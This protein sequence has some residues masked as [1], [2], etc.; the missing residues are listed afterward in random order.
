MKDVAQ[1]RCFVI[2]PIGEPGSATRNRSD[3][4]LEYIIRPA[5]PGWHVERGDEP[6]RP[7]MVG[8]NVMDA[9]FNWELAIAD[10]TDLNPNV[11]YEI[12]LR[13]MEEKPLILIAHKGTG[14]PFDTS[15]VR[16]VFYSLEDPDAHKLASKKIADMVAAVTA[17]GYKVSNPVT[18]ARG[19]LKLARSTDSRDQIVAN[20]AAELAAVKAQLSALSNRQD[21]YLTAVANLKPVITQTSTFDI[22]SLEDDPMYQRLKELSKKHRLKLS[23]GEVPES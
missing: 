20:L 5:L 22:S 23:E 15:G 6:S 19:A 9:I 21:N 16:D 12:A 18:N 1:K 10:M 7:D 4:V 8:E 17:P 11:F 3:I 14:R 2:S 13:H